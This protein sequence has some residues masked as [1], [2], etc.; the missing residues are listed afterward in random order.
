MESYQKT[1][2]K[3]REFMKNALGFTQNLLDNYRE[4]LRE[5]KHPETQVE[6]F[7]NNIDILTSLLDL[8]SNKKD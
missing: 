6:E 2:W 5:E 4:Q 3:D 7:T 8:I 1:R